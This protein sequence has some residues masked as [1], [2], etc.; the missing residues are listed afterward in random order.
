M[1]VSW[2]PVRGAVACHHSS[3]G[4]DFSHTGRGVEGIREAGLN[5]GRRRYARAIVSGGVTSTRSV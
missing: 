1:T 3:G 4:A 5:R 2:R